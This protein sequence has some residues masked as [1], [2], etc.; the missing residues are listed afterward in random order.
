ME[1]PLLGVGELPTS[2]APGVY[3]SHDAEHENDFNCGVEYN[4]SLGPGN[5][6]VDWYGH[7]DRSAGLTDTTVGSYQHNP[8]SKP[9]CV[10]MDPFDRPNSA[11]HDAYPPAWIPVDQPVHQ[12]SYRYLANTF[13]SEEKLVVDNA[14]N[15]SSSVDEYKNA[16]WS[17]CQDFYSTSDAINPNANQSILLNNDS[18]FTLRLLASNTGNG[19]RVLLPGANQPLWKKDGTRKPLSFQLSCEGLLLCDK[20]RVKQTKSDKDL[21]KGPKLEISENDTRPRYIAELFRLAR[22]FNAQKKKPVIQLGFKMYVA[23]QLLKGRWFISDSNGFPKESLGNHILYAEG[24]PWHGKTPAPATVQR[25]LDNMLERLVAKWE[26]LFCKDWQKIMKNQGKSG[27]IE[28]F[29]ASFLILHIIEQD[30]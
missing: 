18:H 12:S 2:A 1:L 28:M 7:L 9:A 22:K 19:F 24:S 21:L 6:I 15:I 5:P 11:V 26:V 16:L 25:Q 20:C 14:A 27:W 10:M 17:T 8:T 3:N 30:A 4:P 29:F 13:I 23:G